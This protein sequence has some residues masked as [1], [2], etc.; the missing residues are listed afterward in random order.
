MEFKRIF[1]AGFWIGLISFVGFFLFWFIPDTVAYPHTAFNRIP[2][3]LVQSGKVSFVFFLFGIVVGIVRVF[4]HSIEDEVEKRV[5]EKKRSLQ[6]EYRKKILKVKEREG[7][8]EEKEK[9]LKTRE[10]DVEEILFRKRLQ[11]E[12][13]D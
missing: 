3:L 12:G 6:E 7:A 13:N 5:T 11:G 2:D 4:V 10:G 1:N 8:L 9:S